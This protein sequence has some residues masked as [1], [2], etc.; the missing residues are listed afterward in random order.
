MNGAMRTIIFDL[1]SVLT[2]WRPRV[3]YRKLVRD[4]E[5]RSWFLAE[6]ARAPWEEDKPVRHNAL[7]EGLR[8]LADRFP[9]RVELTAVLH[10]DLRQVMLANRLPLTATMLEQLRGEG[11]RLLAITDLSSKA[12]AQATQMYPATLG[13]VTDVVTAEE[14]GTPLPDPEILGYALRR[15]GLS[16]EECLYVDESEANVRAAQSVGIA[17]TQYTSIGPLRRDLR[18]R[19][20]LPPS[21]WASQSRTA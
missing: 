16:A 21:R 20:F 8:M 5:L 1:A 15:F 9:A 19:G 7:E 18:E 2:P 12:L 11:V 17:S 6:V 14:V 10:D 4:L 3:L 13:Q